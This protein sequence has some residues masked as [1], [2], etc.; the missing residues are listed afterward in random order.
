MIEWYRI[1]QSKRECVSVKK[2]VYSLI[3]MSF[4]DHCSGC[5]EEALLQF[6]RFALLQRQIV[7]S[8]IKFCF[9]IAIA[10]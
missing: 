6:R 3:L 2:N 10:V 8:Q 9:L 1:D 4:F 5:Y 7:C